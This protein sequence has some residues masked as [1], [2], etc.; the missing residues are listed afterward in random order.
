MPIRF[1]ELF[2]ETNPDTI[3]AEVYEQLEAQFEDWEP[4]AG[5]LETWLT[6][7]YVRIA[8]SV[9]D[10]ASVVSREAFKTFGETI[11]KVPPILAAPA[12]AQSTWKLIDDKGHT[13]EDGTLVR[14]EATGDESLSFRVVGDVEVPPESDETAAGEVLLE[15]VKPGEAYNGLAA[16]PEPQSSVAFVDSIALT[17]AT[18]GGVD[19]EDEDAYLTRLTEELQTLTLSAVLPR[20]YEIL[21]RRAAGV[22]RAT[23]LDNYD[24]DSEETEQPLVISVAVV[25]ADGGALSE[26]V[27][28][29]V[30]ALLEERSLSN[31][32]TFVIDP[33]FTKVKA[34]ATIVVAASFD[35][36]T[37]V[38]A[39]EARLA[40]YLSPAN[41]GIPFTGGPSTSTWQNQ[42]TVYLNEV[43][44]EVDRV[45]GVSRVVG[46]ELA[47]GA[48]ALG[49]SDVELAG[50]APLTEP[51]TLEVVA[52]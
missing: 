17:G 4:A 22:A 34:K 8:A 37:V 42:T 25:D 1:V 18:S 26:G 19:A 40:A 13:I 3:E 50:P 27:K 33:T 45:Q 52:A 10:L 46:V 32:V 31:V 49:K 30:K 24:A 2:S 14:I 12:T 38:A 35:P 20:D 6:K 23:A 29:D 21:S 5:G 39:A 44:A 11:V 15:A 47:K 16:T 36:A 9:F 28:D 48:G 7:A 43:L 41:W 51:G